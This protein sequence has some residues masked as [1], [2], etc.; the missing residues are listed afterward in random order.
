MGKRKTKGNKKIKVLIVLFVLAVIAGGTVL[1]IK[2]ADKLKREEAQETDSTAVETQ[3]PEKVEEQIKI[4]NG[5]TRPFAIMID[6]HT[7][8]WPHAG[9]DKAFIVYEIIVEGGETRL[10]ALF[11]GADVANIGPVRSARH[12]YL[13]YALENDAVYVHYGYSP[14]ALKDMSSLKVDH[15]EGGNESSKDFWRT[16]A[17][18]APHNVLVSSATIAKVIEKKGF[19]ATSDKRL[20]DYSATPVDLGETAVAATTVN[21]PFSKLQTV[22]FEYDAEAG[23]Y[24]RSARGKV[25]TE[26]DSKAQI[27]SKNL[28]ITFVPNSDLKD[29][30]NKDRQTLSNIGTF[31]GYYITEGKSIKI[32]CTKTSRAAQTEYKDLDGN[33]IK[34]ND[35]NTFINIVPTDANVTIQ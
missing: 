17:K 14:Q 21:I 28:I 10:M 6:N 34:V 25:Q 4:F 23:V 13:D 1:G 19:R 9:I 26:M 29:G 11:K 3:E 27:T 5:N 20:L 8:A 31:D 15:I 33:T 16:K 24:K 18:A 7:G 30:E 32:K 35:G 22:K 2:I 12:Y